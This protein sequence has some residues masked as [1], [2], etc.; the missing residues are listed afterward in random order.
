[1][2][3]SREDGALQPV[4]S[5]VKTFEYEPLVRE[6]FISKVHVARPL[7][8]GIVPALLKQEKWED[9]KILTFGKSRTD[10]H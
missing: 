10:K 7:Y 5:S 9:A 6:N 8:S 1:M 4:A 2:G 3:L